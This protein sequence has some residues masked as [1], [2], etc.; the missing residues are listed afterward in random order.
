MQHDMHSASRY[1]NRAEELRVMAENVTDQESRLALLKWA[2]D[3][4]QMAQR[5]NEMLSMSFPERKP[6]ALD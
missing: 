6:R 4:D 5:A 2:E 3:Y 1:R